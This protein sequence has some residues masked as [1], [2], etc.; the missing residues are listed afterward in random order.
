MARRGQLDLYGESYGTQFVQIYAAAHPDRLHALFIDGP[1]D[2]TLTGTEYYDEDVG[3]LR[4]E[5]LLHALDACTPV[6]AC[7]ADR[8]P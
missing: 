6:Q 4:R 2:L 5:T 3:R 7:L 1:V 8:G